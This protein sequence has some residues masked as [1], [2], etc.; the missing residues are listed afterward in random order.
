MPSLDYRAIRDGISLAQVLDLI[1]FVP[2]ER[3]GDQLR[4]PCPIHG[5]TTP[6]SRSFSASLSKHAYR[7]F[8]CGSSGNQ[9]DL[10]A[11]ASGLPLHQATIELC[12]RLGLS[13]PHAGDTRSA[14]ANNAQAQTEKRNP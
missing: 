11:A 13:V 12:E 2:F 6:K 3:R 5:S 7:C 10:W 8:R 14:S 1:G 9:L 4:G